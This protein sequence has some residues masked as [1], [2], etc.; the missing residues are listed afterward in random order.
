MG[1]P[2]LPPVIASD[3]GEH[4]CLVHSDPILT[5]IGD[6]AIGSASSVIPHEG[7]GEVAHIQSDAVVVST[8][9]PPS[10]GILNFTVDTVKLAF[11]QK[12]LGL[13]FGYR[14]SKPVFESD[15]DIHSNNIHPIRSSSSL[16]ID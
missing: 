5:D 10:T 14:R 16:H 4:D 7:S 3:V 11:R 2:P 1:E 15:V 8:V 9:V 6:A 12:L 13:G